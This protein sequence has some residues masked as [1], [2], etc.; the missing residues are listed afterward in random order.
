MNRYDELIITKNGE[1]KL[2]LDLEKGEVANFPDENFI[3][4]KNEEKEEKELC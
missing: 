3:S 2:K 1:Q 4:G